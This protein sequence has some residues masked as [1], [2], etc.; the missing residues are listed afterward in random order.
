MHGPVGSEGVYM[1]ATEDATA[2]WPP[3]ASR[4][5]ERLAGG[6]PWWRDVLRR[7]MLACADAGAVVVFSVSAALLLRGG[8]VTAF[9]VGALLPIWIV[10]AKLHGLYDRDHR[11]LRHLTADELPNIFLWVVTGS[12]LT[13]LVVP[14]LSGQPLPAAGF[15][16]VFAA[17]LVAAVS[18]R[19]AARFVWRR[20]VPPDRTV[21]IGDG[22]LASAAR[23]KLELFHEIHAAPVGM[24][25]LACGLDAEERLQELRAMRPQRLLLASSSFDDDLLPRLIAFCR[26]E[27]A[28][29]TVVPPARGQ[30]GT[31]V[32]LG[33]VAE[34]RV[35]EYNTTDVSRSTILLK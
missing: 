4:E 21:I 9:W 11:A 27:G 8:I 12:V 35:L 10:L 1:A 16:E 28:K 17:T 6:R 19:A 31:A 29:L 34:L 7:R 33:R 14:R 24:V 30:L 3:A 23:R 25:S 2:L 22:P 18:F 15:L 20:L 5:L 26:S 13:V 32:Q